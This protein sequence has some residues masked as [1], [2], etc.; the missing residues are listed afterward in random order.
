[1][2]AA[3]TRIRAPSAK[4]KAPRPVCTRSLETGARYQ[5]SSRLPTTVAAPEHREALV[6]AEAA[7][8]ADELARQLARSAQ[9]SGWRPP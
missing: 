1:M 2:V 9:S 8:I 3:A 4:L 6:A 7:E 5:G